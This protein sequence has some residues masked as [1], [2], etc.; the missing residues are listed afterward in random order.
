MSLSSV[1]SPE[2]SCGRAPK[3]PA[4]A[5]TITSACLPLRR[6]TAFVTLVLPSDWYDSSATI[7]PP[8]CVNRTLNALTTSLK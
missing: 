8:S 5:V 2:I 3:A 4:V 7:L 1:R 6:L